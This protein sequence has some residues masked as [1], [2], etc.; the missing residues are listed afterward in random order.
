MLQRGQKTVVGMIVAMLPVVP[1]GAV[2]PQVYPRGPRTAQIV[3]MMVLMS[4]LNR[5]MW[6]PA[7]G[8]AERAALA[9]RDL[10]MALPRAGFP[11]PAAAAE[12]WSPACPN[13]LPAVES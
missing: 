9:P 3:P 1:L 12:N 5:K 11:R 10:V 8:I 4:C 13:H 2:A 6:D 7:A